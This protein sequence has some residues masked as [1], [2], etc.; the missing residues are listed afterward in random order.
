[1]HKGICLARRSVIWSKILEYLGLG[2]LK[3]K[4]KSNRFDQSI[5]TGIQ[6]VEGSKGKQ[7]V[8]VA[9]DF[10]TVNIFCKLF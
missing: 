2:F 1:M 4:K 8:F 9:A 6:Y 3:T 5:D 10:V 7:N